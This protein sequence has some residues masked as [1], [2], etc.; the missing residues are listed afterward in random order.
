MIDRLNR[1]TIPYKTSLLLGMMGFNFLL[2]GV[3]V[4]MAHSQNNFFR[5]ELI[6]LIFS[7]LAVLAI[8]AQ[9]IIQSNTVIKKTFQTV[10]WLGVLVGVVGTFFHLTGNAT[11]SQESLHRL[12]IEGSPVAAPIAFAG[13]SCYALVSEHYRGTARRSKLLLLMGLGFLGAVVAAFLDHA[14]LAFIPSYTL[15]PLVSGILA[16]IAC[17]YIAYT[18]ADPKEIYIYLSILALNMLVG[19]VGFGFHVWGDLAGTQSIIWARF[20]YRNPLLGPL[21][22][23]NL[24]LL[25]GLSLLPESSVMLEESKREETMPLS[26]S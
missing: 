10:M 23:C 26:T 3:D 24:A 21:L 11:S 9:V 18:Q 8:L 17:F 7:P 6:P 25:G 4:V 5:W 20:L 22:F 12:L 1:L 19:L 2:T 16:A 15:I 14:R 13:I